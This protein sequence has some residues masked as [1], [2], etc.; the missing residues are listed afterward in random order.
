[1]VFSCPCGIHG[2]WLPVASTHSDALQCLAL[3][4]HTVYLRLGPVISSH[5]HKC[6]HITAPKHPSHGLLPAATS[7]RQTPL[8]PTLTVPPPPSHPQTSHPQPTPSLSHLSLPP[9]PSTPRPTAQQPWVR[10]PHAQDTQTAR[11]RTSRTRPGSHHPPS[12]A[13]DR[14]WSRGP[15][16]RQARPPGHDARPRYRRRRTV[17]SSSSG[18]CG[19]SAGRG[20][21][22]LWRREMS[23]ALVEEFVVIL[24]FR[25]REG[26]VDSESQFKAFVR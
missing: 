10:N 26:F 2:P 1:M 11:R 18:R 7:T 5:P 15:R 20:G 24:L 4:V 8:S 9:P 22:L 25:G 19:A 12:S 21:A 14:N 6:R 16:R 23:L 17:R 3:H 13:P